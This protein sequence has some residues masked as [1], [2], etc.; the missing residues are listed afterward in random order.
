MGLYTLTANALMSILLG[1]SSLRNSTIGNDRIPNEF[2]RRVYA[3]ISESLKRSELLLHIIDTSD[4]LITK[5]NSLRDIDLFVALND[6]LF[7]RGGVHHNNDDFYIKNRL[8]KNKALIFKEFEKC[9]NHPKF[10][11]LFD[12]NP[13]NAGDYIPRYVRV[14]YNKTTADSVIEQFKSEG[15]KYLEDIKVSQLKKSLKPKSKVFCTDEHLPEVL[16]FPPQTDFHLHDLYTSGSIILQ[17]KASCFPA[18]ILSPPQ[19]SIVIDACAAP[20]NKTSHLSM[21][22]K[23]TGSIIACDLDSYRLGTLVK[24]TGIA[25]CTNIE[26]RNISFLDIDP[27]SDFGKS[28]THI[29]LDPSCSG[30]GMVNKLEQLVDSFIQIYFERK[31][32]YSVKSKLSRGLK[33]DRLDNLSE[34]QVEMLNHAMKCNE[35]FALADKIHVLPKWP[36]RGINDTSD[37]SDADLNDDELES[38]IRSSSDKMH[39]NGFFVACFINLLTNDKVPIFKTIPN[40]L[41]K[42]YMK[43]QGENKNDLN[44]D[45]KNELGENTKEL[46]KS[47][48]KIQSKLNS[49]T[50]SVNK[51]YASSLDDKAAIHSKPV[52]NSKKHSKQPLAD[53]SLD[54]NKLVR[55]KVKNEQPESKKTSKR[56]KVKKGVRS[57]ITN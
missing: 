29:L 51:P 17:D 39:T 25:G 47:T 19:D 14:N 40:S 48:V 4:I 28:V 31:K 1:K 52:I 5:N 26:A 34:F 42:Q 21:L 46:L 15:Y 8:I 27:E 36:I 11:H 3:S 55:E 53:Y 54:R 6:L 41:R 33:K 38:V 2:K 37:L 50:E 18:A 10:A 16:V 56:R 57:A 43:T 7:A 20:G 24:Q 9:K 22:M 23:N 13:S 32:E 45:G 44:K 49:S 12:Q 35:N 30:S